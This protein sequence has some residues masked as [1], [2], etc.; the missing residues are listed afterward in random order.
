MPAEHVMYI[1]YTTIGNTGHCH[2]YIQSQLLLLYTCIY[3]YIYIYTYAT[4]TSSVI[5][6][7]AATV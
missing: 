2:S 4:H 1:N 7:S 3:V 6:V 5:A